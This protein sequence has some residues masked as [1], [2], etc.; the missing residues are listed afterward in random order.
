MSVLRF[1][2]CL[3][4]CVCA[5]T[6]TTSTSADIVFFQFLQASAGTGSAAFDQGAAGASFTSNESAVGVLS[7]APATTLTIVDI[8]APEFVDN[9]GDGDPETLSGVILTDLVDGNVEVN[10]SGND[11]LGIANPSISNADF[12]AIIGNTNSTEGGDLNAGEGFTF[13][14]DQDVTFTNIEFESVSD[15]DVSVLDV[16]IA[17]GPSFTFLESDGTLPNGNLANPFGSTLITA[18]TDITFTASASDGSL[19][20]VDFRIESFTVD[21][22]TIP[23]PSSGLALLALTGLVASRRRR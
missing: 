12:G 1:S 16:S 17:G 7:T 2:I 9:D 14:F 13:E 11:A 3:L 15:G 4:A 23:E 5:G 21:V 8:F 20:V 22:E 6:L 19:A 10:N 18:G